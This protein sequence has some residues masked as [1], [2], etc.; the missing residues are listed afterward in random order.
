MSIQDSYITSRCDEIE[1]L[2]KDCK[3]WS[4][5]DPKLGAHLATYIDVMILGNLEVCCEYLV[6]KR[7]NKTGDTETGNYISK[8]IEDR[9]KNPNYGLICGI[10][11]Q[12][13]DVYIDDF[14]K[15]FK[16]DSP[17]VQALNALNENKTQVAH[18]G[19]TNLNLSIN[20]VEI[21]FRSVT[22]ILEKLEN[23]LS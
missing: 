16:K 1:I 17:E 19:L 15:T 4:T 9:F 21:Y 23:I 7:A 12:F 6:K 5:N 3:T 11:H 13:S 2:L 8:H 22:K 20:D 14:Q 18:Y 10:L